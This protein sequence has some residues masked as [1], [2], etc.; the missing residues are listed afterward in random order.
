MTVFVIENHPIMR[1]ALTMLIHRLRPGL[2]VVPVARIN[3]LESAVEAK[4]PADLFCL[5]L[6][7][8]DT[9]GLS[10]L[11]TIKSKYPDVPLAVITGSETT[12]FK[13]L[14]LRSGADV[15]I[16]K[17]CTAA[18][19]L[20]ELRGVLDVPEVVGGAVLVKLTKRQKQLI[21]MLD[22][23]LSNRDIAK[24]LDISDNTVKVH[25]NRLFRLIGVT[26]R[27]QTLNFARTNGWL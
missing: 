9:L 23:G 7:L 27:T 20:S 4:G 25:F 19:I 14:C 17:T 22:Q 5:D 11:H 8:S 26:S 15:F 18:Q 6:Q 12:Q 21:L 1:D 3:Q 13:N 24:S 2:K 16:E 10:G